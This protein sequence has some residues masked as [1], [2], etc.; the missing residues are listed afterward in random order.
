MRCAIFFLATFPVFGQAIT[1]GVAG[2]VPLTNS[3]DNGTGGPEEFH[4]SGK[5]IRYTIGPEVNFR[6]FGPFRGEI[7]ALYQPFSFR[8]YCECG[9]GASPTYFHTSGALWQ[10]PALVRYRLPTPLL[11]SFIEAG[12]AVQLAA[13]IAESS[14]NVLQPS[15]ITTLHPGPNAVAGFAFGGGFEF[16]AHPFIFTPDSLHALL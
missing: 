4:F 12:P 5:T 7:D 3:F 14:Y 10:F 13:N 16:R 15:L 8:E 2:G 1:A 9:G 11:K 6:I